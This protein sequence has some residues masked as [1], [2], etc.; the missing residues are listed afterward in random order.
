MAEEI[1]C[2]TERLLGPEALERLKSSRVAVFGIGGVGGHLCEA[3]VRSGVGSVDIIDKDVVDITN[4][5]RQIIALQSTVGRPKVEVMRER[6]L[7]INPKLRIRC[8]PMF[9]L[10][11]NA[12]E[13]PFSEFDY[14]ADAIDTVTAKI[15][16][17]LKAQEVGVPVISAMGAGNKLDPGAFKIA[18]IYKTKVCPLARVMRYEMRKRGVRSLKVVYSEE[19][20]VQADPDLLAALAAEE[21]GVRRSIPGSNAF[22]P[23]AAGLLIAR[24]VIRDLAA[25]AHVS[26]S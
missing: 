21:G 18:D 20:P 2:R 26:A 15:E 8:Y 5:N 14:V 22:V 17:I 3:L 11:E 25:S 24:A 23:S 19:L 16:L 10:P 9:F 1:F 12:S 4:L 7:D 6:L 13:L